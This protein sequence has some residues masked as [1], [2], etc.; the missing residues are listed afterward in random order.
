METP[1]PRPVVVLVHGLARS[2]GSLRLMSWWLKRAGFDT[3]D[4]RYDSRHQS[5]AR[6]VVEVE[7]QVETLAGLRK[8]AA[9]HMMGHSLGGIIALKVKRKR[10]DLPIGRVVQLG[11]PNRGSGLAEALREHGW[12]RRFFGPVLEELAEDQ[13]EGWTR[14]PD[15]LAFAGIEIPPFLAK[16]YGVLGP[17]DGMVNV[18]SAWGRDAGVR[19]SVN[20][21]H[22]GMPL[23]PSVARQAI[24]FLKDGRIEE[25]EA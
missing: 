10:P 20:T 21:F 17:N 13:S 1:D 4:T 18:R 25:E 2:S 16:R 5:L 15:V 24:A 19:R 8:G 23:S 14:D 12:A 9:L 6:S 22:G 11:S 7:R 3:A